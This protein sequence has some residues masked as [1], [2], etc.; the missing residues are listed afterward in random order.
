MTVHVYANLILA[1]SMMGD[2]DKAIGVMEQMLRAKAWEPLILHA[3]SKQVEQGAQCS[4]AA[5]SV[6]LLFAGVAFGHC[7]KIPHVA[8]TWASQRGM[9]G[10]LVGKERC[11]FSG[12]RTEAAR[13]RHVVGGIEHHGPE[14]P[15]CAFQSVEQLCLSACGAEVVGAVLCRERMGPVGHRKGAAWASFWTIEGPLTTRARA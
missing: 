2:L 3:P 5:C 7:L 4:R 9:K 1:A 12:I 14:G 13:S 8:V 10:R 6:R 15:A 11:G